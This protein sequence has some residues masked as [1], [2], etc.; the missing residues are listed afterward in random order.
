MAKSALKAVVSFP[1]KRRRVHEKKTQLVEKYV[2]K[3][4]DTTYLMFLYY[5][6][7]EL[8]GGGLDGAWFTVKDV[9]RIHKFKYSKPLLNVFKTIVGKYVD[10]AEHAK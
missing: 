3:V 6:P 10:E 8:K 2:T 7:E 4:G 5:V 9:R 1:P